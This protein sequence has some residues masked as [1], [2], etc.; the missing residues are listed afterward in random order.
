MSAAV[1][2]TP[3]LGED[4]RAAAADAPVAVPDT[5]ATLLAL[6]GDV[7]W[8]DDARV[9]AAVTA[10][11]RRLLAP[12]SLDA[13]RGTDAVLRALLAPGRYVVPVGTGCVGV[14]ASHEAG[15][16]YVAVAPG[17]V[18]VDA[19]VL[20]RW[21]E[22]EAVGVDAFTAPERA[23]QRT[24]WDRVRAWTALECAVKAGRADLL[25]PHDRASILVAGTGGAA[26]VDGDGVGLHLVHHGGRL[27]A[28]CVRVAVT[29]PHAAPSTTVPRS[30]AVAAGRVP[31]GAHP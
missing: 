8:R 20:D 19:C 24:P 1:V 18:V 3:D 23:A 13:R 30:A 26:V 4:R 17:A 29:P 6:P 10:V 9:R 7:R 27:R 2:P 14:S 11:A 16:T 5:G 21:R 31:V 22:V 25:R 28:V 15:R 12:G